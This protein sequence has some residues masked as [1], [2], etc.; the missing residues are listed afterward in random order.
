MC[1]PFLQVKEGDEIPFSEINHIYRNHA[2]MLQKPI[3]GDCPFIVGKEASETFLLNP[4]SYVIICFTDT[5]GDEKKM[6]LS[7]TSQ[8]EVEFS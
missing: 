7:V 8:A 4:G 3:A 5:P 1:A 6:A 2:D